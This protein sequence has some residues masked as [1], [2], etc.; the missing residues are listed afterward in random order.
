MS[1]DSDASEVH[2]NVFV[3]PTVIG[4]T[5]NVLGGTSV[6]MPPGPSITSQAWAAIM[7]AWAFCPAV[8]RWTQTV[9]S[10]EFF[11]RFA[12]L[13][14]ALVLCIWLAGGAAVLLDVAGYLLYRH[15][16]VAQRVVTHPVTW[17]LRLC[18]VTLG[19]AVLAAVVFM[20]DR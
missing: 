5:Q 1:Q 2:H 17:K 6:L 11:S 7:A 20:M 12:D 15:W 19:G 14:H 10:E 16:A 3:G 9:L 13:G 4:G 8:A 18:A